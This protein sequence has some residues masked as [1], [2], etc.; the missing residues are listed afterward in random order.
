MT[1]GERLKAVWHRVDLYV[2][3]V[4]LVVIV[5]A[6]SALLMN[7]FNSHERSVLIDRFPVVR[8]EERAACTREF[9]AKL[10]TAQATATGAAALQKQT[11]ADMTD[12]KALMKT[13]NDLVAY[14]LRFL[15]DRA[16]HADQVNATVLKQTK[17]AAEAAVDAKQ[18]AKESDQKLSAVAVEAHDAKQTATAVGKQLE[19][20]TRPPLPAKPWI[21]NQR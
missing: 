10:D 18:T 12:L 5:A 17:V 21:G 13:T 14:T 4:L 6:V 16:K 11:A 15:G 8:A 2:G 7:W 20:A 9:S 19:T 1:K 3:N